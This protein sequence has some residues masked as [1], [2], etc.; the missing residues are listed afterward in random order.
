MLKKAAMAGSESGCQVTTTIGGIGGLVCHLGRQA[1]HSQERARYR[2]KGI[3]YPTAGR[4]LPALDFRFL[5]QA[6]R[7]SA[8]SQPAGGAA[9]KVV[10]TGC[11]KKTEGCVLG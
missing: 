1:K 8:C 3:G 2:T 7:H 6:S 11:G 10:P 4:R 5:S 9:S